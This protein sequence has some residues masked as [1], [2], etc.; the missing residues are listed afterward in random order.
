[1]G[2]P[3]YSD[4]P[5]QHGPSFCLGPLAGAWSCYTPPC[6]V[7]SGTKITAAF[8]SSDARECG[9]DLSRCRTETC[10]TEVLHSN[11]EKG[12]TTT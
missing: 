12:G 2:L 3:S 6:P 9:G 8:A 1:Q 4:I 11:Q 5:P 7:Q 10:T